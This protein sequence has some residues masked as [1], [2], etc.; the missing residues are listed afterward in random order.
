MIII[1]CKFLR[2]PVS[3]SSGI[4]FVSGALGLNLGPLKLETNLATARHRCCISL[5]EV[6]FPAGTIRQRWAPLYS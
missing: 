1:Y 4:A 6:A 5:K 2:R 3:R